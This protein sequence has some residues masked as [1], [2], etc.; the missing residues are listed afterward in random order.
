M[1]ST[2]CPNCG[3]EAKDDKD[4]LITKYNG[5]GECPQCGII[6]QNN[7]PVQPREL[8]VIRD[9]FGQLYK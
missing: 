9:R 3:Y 5:I 2:F 1:H 4:P 8:Q 6:V 7:I